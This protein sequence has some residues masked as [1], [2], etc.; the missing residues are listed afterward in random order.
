MGNDIVFQINGYI[1]DVFF[2]VDVVFTCGD[3]A[4]ASPRSDTA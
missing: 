3:N 4:W 2:A 1:G